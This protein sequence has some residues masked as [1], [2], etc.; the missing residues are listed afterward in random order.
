MAAS[1][2]RLFAAFLILCAAPHGTCG[3]QALPETA[4]GRFNA[5]DANHDGLISKYEYD[6]DT[7]FAAMDSNHNNRISA[8]EVQGILGPQQ[9]GTPSA[10]QR[11]GVADMNGDKELSDE[12]LRRTLESRFNWL[13]TNRDG[14]V[15]LP[16]MTA[17]FGVPLL[18]H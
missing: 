4:E 8:A 5:L 12:E 17:G 9:E 11:V 18:T 15:D 6:S 3:A 10:S 14:S 7:A 16:E 1:T 2:L 13:D